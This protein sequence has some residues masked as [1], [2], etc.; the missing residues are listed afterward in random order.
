M[1]KHIKI[2]LDYHN[3]HGERIMCQCCERQEAV[4]VHHIEPKGMGGSDQKDF[5]ENLIALCRECHN[6]AHEEK[7][8]KMVLKNIVR[9]NL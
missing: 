4:D 6:A 3:L 7:V 9:Q 5:I 8:S 1:K 2:F